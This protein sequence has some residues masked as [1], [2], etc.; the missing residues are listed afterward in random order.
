[1]FHK[2]KEI[3]SLENLTITVIF[4]GGI[5]KIYDVRQMFTVFPQME[6]LKDEALFKM[7]VLDPGGYGISWNDD[8][9]IDAEE[10]W[11]N[12]IEISKTQIDI[13]EQVGMEIANLRSEKKITQKE[14]AKLTG[15]SQANISRL[16]KGN[17]NPS[18]KILSKIANGLNVQ[19]NLQ[20]IQPVIG[21]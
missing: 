2:I 19:L 7:A 12:G 9:D 13:A 14:L 8:L 4:V 11:D 16:E 5:K 15:I 17:L 20:F 18:L 3:T 1:M 10:I 21:K 6:E